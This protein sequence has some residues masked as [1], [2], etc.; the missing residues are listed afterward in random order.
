MPVSTECAAALL[1]FRYPSFSIITFIIIRE[2]KTIDQFPIPKH[3]QMWLPFWKLVAFN[4]IITARWLWRDKAKLLANHSALFSII[5]NVI[6]LKLKGTGS[7]FSA[8]SFIRMLFSVWTRCTSAWTSSMQ[9]IWSCHNVVKEQSAHPPGSHL[10]L[11]NLNIC[12]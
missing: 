12:K 5:I 9:A 1:S 10:H 3:Q 2:N 6:I 7:R 11:I 8:C 4:V